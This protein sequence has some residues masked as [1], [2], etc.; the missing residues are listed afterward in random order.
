MD[1]QY[2]VSYVNPVTWTSIGLAY[3]SSLSMDVIHGGSTVL[4]LA[5]LER[6]WGKKLHRIKVK[7]GICENAKAE[8]DHT[9]T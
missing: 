1:M 3:L 6:S 9:C 5:L 8:E 4:F 2:I 7:Y